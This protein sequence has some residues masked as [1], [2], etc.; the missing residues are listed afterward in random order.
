M[1]GSPMLGGGCEFGDYI[2]A[3]TKDAVEFQIIFKE[4]EWKPALDAMIDMVN[5]AKTYGFSASEIA[6]V[7]AEL[8]ADYENAFNERDKRKNSQLTRSCINHFKDGESMLGIEMEYQIVQQL[9]EALPNEVYNQAFQEGLTDE[10]RF[11]YCMAQEKEG[12][13]LPTE[14]ELVKMLKEGFAREAMPYEEAEVAAQLMETLPAKGSI[15]KEEDTDFGFKVWTL[16][17]GA[18]VVWKQTDYKKDQIMMSAISPV[19]YIN[20]NGLSYAEQ[21]YISSACTLG[22]FADFSV[23]DLQ[24]VLA[25]KKASLDVT[26][27]KN[28]VSF[29]GSST[30]KDFRCMMEQMYL[31]MTQPRVDQEAYDSWFKRVR[32]S[33]ATQEG[34]PDK[35]QSDSLIFTFY[36]G[37]EDMYPTTLDELDKISYKN[38]F[39]KGVSLAKNAADYTFFLI[40]NIE[41]DSLR[42]MAEQYIAALPSAGKPT[43]NFKREY[44]AMTPGSRENRFDLPMAQAMTTV[45]NIFNVY[46]QQYNMKEQLAVSL[47]AQIAQMTFTETIRER[48]GGVYSPGATAGYNMRNGLIQMLYYFVTG[49]DK[50]AHIEDVAYKETCKMA[51]EPISEDYFQKARDYMLKAHKERLIENGYWLNQITEKFR[52]GNDTHTGYEET[53]NAITPADVQAVAKKIIYGGNRIQFISN[54]VEKK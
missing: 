31:A 32:N 39:D 18:K 6:R 9:L 17:N 1:K 34:T 4:N 35:I 24:K 3:K 13:V 37:Q 52:F 36:K 11:I 47:F 22:G 30:P 46:D 40:G 48:E 29:D 15:V 43:E 25:G 20:L 54:G 28:A 27:D 49:E 50:L 26:I 51:D 44:T 21:N 45:Y 14:E 42:V 16:S 53:L 7:K 41:E 2:T 12:S 33:L 8:L 19:G 23:M 38:M 5:T 10:N